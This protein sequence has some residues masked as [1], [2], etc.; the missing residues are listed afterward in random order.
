MEKIIKVI[1]TLI[2]TN[3]C[4]FSLYAMEKT[5]L[6][7]SVNKEPIHFEANVPDGFNY[8]I[9]IYLNRSAYY[10]TNA[11][12][13]SIDISLIPG[14]YEVRTIISNDTDDR[15]QTTHAETLNT[16]INSSFYIA[17]TTNE[18]TEELDIG[19]EHDFEINEEVSETIP[20]PQIFDFSGGKEYG[21]LLIS[22]ETYSAI[23]SAIFRLVGEDDIYDIPLTSEYFGR[24]EV[25][26][27]VGSYYESSS[28]DVELDK[29]A[30]LPEGFSFLWQH[31][32]KPGIW[33]DYYDIAAGQSYNLDDL[34][35]VISSGSTV[36]EVS[37]NLLFSKTYTE[38]RNSVRERDRQKELESAFPEIY[39]T[40]EAETIA[41]AQPVEPAADYSNIIQV[42][43]IAVLV[44]TVIGIAAL[45]IR[46]RKS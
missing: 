34:I 35:I 17:V 26:L 5:E 13:Y 32:D 29:D 39:G 2:I 21:T 11:S 3:I 10:M 46:R 19:E 28:I 18:N 42:A 43:V 12:G 33:G 1:I 4:C 9:E 25:R 36:S 20:A 7:S 14:E 24:A 44:L 22:S 41:E 6:P 27:P 31:E 38:N 15:Y 16:T 45:I 30:S 37:S 40:S 8:D 23:E